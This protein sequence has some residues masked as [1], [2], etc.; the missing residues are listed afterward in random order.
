MQHSNSI[1]NLRTSLWNNLKTVFDKFQTK[2]GEMELHTVEEFL[3][4]VL[5]Q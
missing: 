3:R 1:V 5:G 2:G 4:T